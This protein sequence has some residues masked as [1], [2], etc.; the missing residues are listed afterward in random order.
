MRLALSLLVLAGCGGAI[1]APQVSSPVGEGAL[2]VEAA[3]G[4]VAMEPVCFAEERCDALDTNC[5]GSID[6]GC[7]GDLSGALEVGLAWDGPGVLALVLDGPGADAAL[8]LDASGA[9]DDPTGSRTAHRAL[10]ALEPGAY[11]VAVEP[12]DTCEA[13]GPRTASVT[14]AARGRVLGIWNVTVEGSAVDV[15]RLRVES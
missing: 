12:A 7:E 8:S 11:R 4:A 1:V 14:I 6:E 3:P 15:V 5:D 10:V 9:C 2:S 13:E